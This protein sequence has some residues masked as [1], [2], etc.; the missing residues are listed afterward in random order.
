MMQRET[1]VTMMLRETRVTMTQREANVTALWQSAVVVILCR[2]DQ[3]P[4]RT[5]RK[6]RG[7]QKNVHTTHSLYIND[8]ANL[9]SITD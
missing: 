5:V 6:E 8:A 3:L 1:R 9:L 2:W 4:Q 7:S